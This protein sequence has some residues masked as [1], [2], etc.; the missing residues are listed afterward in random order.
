MQLRSTPHW[1]PNELSIPAPGCLPSVWALSAWRPIV[2]NALAIGLARPDALFQGESQS[3][4]GSAVPDELAR[5]ALPDCR[6]QPVSHPTRVIG[7][8]IKLVVQGQVFHDRA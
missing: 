6:Q 7:I 3:L 8:T 1:F 2:C 4:S 5:T